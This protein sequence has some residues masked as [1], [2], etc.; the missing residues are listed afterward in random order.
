MRVRVLTRVIPDNGN[1]GRVAAGTQKRIWGSQVEW[2]GA[3]K[4]ALTSLNEQGELI[5]G[6]DKRPG[7][8]ELVVSTHRGERAVAVEQSNRRGDAAPR[9]GRS[10]S[11]SCAR[12]HPSVRLGVPRH[13]G[14]AG[15]IL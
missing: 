6:G 2:I 9:A 7:H 8:R 11:Q 12:K 3:V 1:C 4:D 15:R 5:S 10:R 13:I 14:V